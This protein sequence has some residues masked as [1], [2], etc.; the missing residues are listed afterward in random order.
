[1]SL[2]FQFF[3]ISLRTVKGFHECFCKVFNWPVSRIDPHS[4]PVGSGFI[5]IATVQFGYDPAI[6]QGGF[7]ASGRANNSRESVFQ[8]KLKDSF[9]LAIPS[10]K[11]MLVIK[12]EW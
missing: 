4:P 5:Q 6:Y 8:Q 12:G 10:K 7:T 2:S 11:Q 1:M 9:T 3:I